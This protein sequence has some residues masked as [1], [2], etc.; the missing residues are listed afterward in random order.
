MNQIDSLG[1]SFPISGLVCFAIRATYGAWLGS[2]IDTEQLYTKIIELS[3]REYDI[4]M[5]FLKSVAFSFF[6]A[7][8]H[9]LTQILFLVSS[10]A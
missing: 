10:I 1:K 6:A 9:R 8:S 3:L 7:D 4:F 2:L 5:V